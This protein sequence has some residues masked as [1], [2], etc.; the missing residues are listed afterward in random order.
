MRH[1]ILAV[2]AL[3][4]VRTGEAQNTLS[5]RLDGAYVQTNTTIERH[6]SIGEAIGMLERWRIEAEIRQKIQTELAPAIAA[7][8]SSHPGDGALIA[9]DVYTDANGNATSRVRLEGFAPDA[10]TAE[11]NARNMSAVRSGPPVGALSSFQKDDSLSYSAFAKLDGTTVKTTM[12]V[13]TLAGTTGHTAVQALKDV[14]DA[15]E[16]QIASRAE[17]QSTSSKEGVTSREARGGGEKP[18]KKR[19]VS[20]TV[21]EQLTFEL[22][23]AEKKPPKE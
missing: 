11:T 17:S 7:H 15:I 9:V 6:A 3:L 16:A 22:K 19:E 21:G 4:L 20:V 10:Q 8:M 23:P 1:S 13:K 12:L 14:G 2:A 18:E 5:S